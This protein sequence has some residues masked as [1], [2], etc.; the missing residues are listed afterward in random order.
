MNNDPTPLLQESEKKILELLNTD[1]ELSFTFLKIAEDAE[2]QPE[3]RERNIENARKAYETTA[4]WLERLRPE[5]VEGQE[6]RTKHQR[7][8]E[9]LEELG[10]KLG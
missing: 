5:D 4:K 1:M 10:V 9:W 8:G 2:A 3:K 7:L 6:I